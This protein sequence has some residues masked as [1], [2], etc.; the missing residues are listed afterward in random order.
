[1][2][3]PS[4]ASCYTA[5]SSAGHRIH[6]GSG[7]KPTLLLVLFQLCTHAAFAQL[8]EQKTVA[9]EW[10]PYGEVAFLG[11]TKVSLQFMPHGADST[12]LLLMW[13]ERPELKSYFSIKFSSQGKTVRA[14]HDILISFFEKENWNRKDYIRVF[15]LGND[16]VSVY[17][18]PVLA[19]RAIVL[20]TDKGRIS[21]R[22]GEIQ[23]L[24]N[25]D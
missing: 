14:L 20:K 22:K 9:G 5:V 24:F 3:S 11:E 6:P 17:K 21:L 12:F 2:P 4:P 8:T 7:I 19:S 25:V 18:S 15:T 10:Q 13:D 23:K 1:M 16:K